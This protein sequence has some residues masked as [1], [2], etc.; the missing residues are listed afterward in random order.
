[1]LLATSH[2]V[3]A[4]ENFAHMCTVLVVAACHLLIVSDN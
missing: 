1:M 3:C 2:S 4:E